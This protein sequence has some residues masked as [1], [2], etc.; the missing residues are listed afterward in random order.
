MKIISRERI[1]GGRIWEAMGMQSEI[2]GLN[3]G[4]M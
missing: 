1:S 4:F 2:A 3:L